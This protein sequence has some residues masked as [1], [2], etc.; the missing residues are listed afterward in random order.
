MKGKKQKKS[1]N[2]FENTYNRNKNR[3]KTKTKSR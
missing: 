1:T 2:I 3:N